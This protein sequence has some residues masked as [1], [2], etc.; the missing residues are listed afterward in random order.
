MSKGILGRVGKI[1]NRMSR[2][3][4]VM[5]VLFGI[6]ILAFVWYSFQPTVS[7]SYAKLG[8]R[9]VILTLAEKAILESRSSVLQTVLQSGQVFEVRVEAGDTVEKG[10]VIAV[11]DGGMMDE[12]RMALQAQLRSLEAKYREAV[13]PPDIEM[14]SNS[15]GNIAL[16]R[17][18][19]ADAERKLSQNKELFDSGAISREDYL[20][21]TTT[22]DAAAQTLEAAVNNL[23]LLK[24]GV[25]DAVR[26]SYKS[27][28]DV[29]RANM[30]KL[31]KQIA[32]GVVRAIKEGVA[33][34]VRVKVGDYVVVGSPI[35]GIADMG[36]LYLKSDI[37]DSDIIRVSDGLK[38]DILVDGKR[39]KGHV[40]K[41][42][43]MAFEKVSELGLLQKRVR[44]DLAIGEDLKGAGLKRPILGQ[45]L[46]VEFILDLREN[47][48]AIRKEDVFN[49]DDKRYVL[50]NRNGKLAEQ[51]VEI[52]LEG[53][54][55]V[56]VVSGLSEGDIYI[57]DVD[58][59]V[60][61]GTRIR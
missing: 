47:V 6:I 26:D 20:A 15:E 32:E 17:S 19:L 36:D 44:V 45:E 46:D 41:V 35:V 51:T 2:R 4:K 5:M 37:M 33:T 1:N 3:N 59:K 28:I 34:D 53:D 56:E 31:D 14:V 23:A 39:I 61:I 52:G 13:R 57:D 29:L 42:H 24:K 12:D 60:K 22:R 10:Q 38:V 54:E 48:L 49:K 8:S 18:S 16:A 25:S 7:P 11:L 21:S 58:S 40:E 30:T 50:V 9:D 55:Y 27:E 43:P